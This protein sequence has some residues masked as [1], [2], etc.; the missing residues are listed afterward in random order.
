MHLALSPRLPVPP[1]PIELIDL[2]HPA[3]PEAL[4]GLTILHIS[5][6]HAR[7]DLTATDRWK[8]I[9]HALAITPADLVVVTGD[10]M[11]EPGHEQAALATMHALASRWRP[12]FG[13]FAVLGN[14]DSPALAQRLH[15]IKGLTTLGVNAPAHFDLSIPHSPT[16]VTLRLLGLNAPEDP[17][18]VLLSAPPI[19]ADQ[20][21]FTLALAHHP[22]VL[23]AAADLHLPL[24]LAGHTHAGQIRL[25]PRLAPH[26]SSD[27]PPHLASGMLRLR[28][29][30]CCISRGIG[31][32]VV[33]GL[34]INC[35]AQ[36]PLYTLRSAPLPPTRD[37]EAVAQ[38][39]PW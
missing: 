19:P 14:H 26:T 2:P 30:L 27:L 1:A 35:P 32:G 28:S 24:V 4:D 12:R 18:G 9:L 8:A 6:L 13:A 17:L 3:L 31:D 5:D 11:D 33:E 15:E 34:R 39:V 38:V 29:T 21:S 20:P 36:I 16:P 37:P 10:L 22:T 7:R 23:I 25:H